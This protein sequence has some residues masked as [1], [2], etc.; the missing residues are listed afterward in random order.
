MHSPSGWSEPGQQPEF[1]EFTVVLR[2]T[3]RVESKAARWKCTPG[4]P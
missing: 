1:D 2:G 3:L 4:R